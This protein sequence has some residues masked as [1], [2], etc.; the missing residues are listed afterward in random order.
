LIR[1]CLNL[2]FYVLRVKLISSMALYYYASL[3]ALLLLAIQVDHSSAIMCYQCDSQE[4]SSCPDS[5]YFDQRTNAL[6]DCTSFQARVPGTFCVKIYQES[7]GWHSWIKVTRRCGSRPERIA[8]GCNYRFV[9]MGV[10]RETCYCSDK[11]GCNSSKS[12]A[13]SASTLCLT[14][15]LLLVLALL[16]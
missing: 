6:I 1:L 7:T 4:D 3:L 5:R 12:L 10:Y 2:T 14:G 16:R 13:A 8:W 11:D 9:D 15:L